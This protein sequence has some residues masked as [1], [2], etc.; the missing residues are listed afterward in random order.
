MVS[1]GLA[2]AAAF[3]LATSL[4][5]SAFTIQNGNRVGV[6]VGVRSWF[7]LPGIPKSDALSALAGVVGSDTSKKLTKDM[8][9]EQDHPI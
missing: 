9:D 7:R 2:K 5:T 6:R 3:L 1:A 8:E 4:S